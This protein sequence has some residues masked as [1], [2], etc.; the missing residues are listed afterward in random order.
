IP[1]RDW[2]QGMTQGARIAPA[3]ELSAFLEA[4]P[5]IQA[6]Q[7]MITDPSGV[8]R[9]KSVRREELQR[10]FESG[11][12]V[13]GSILGLDITGKDVDDTGLVWDT[14]DADMTARPIAGTLTRAPWLAVPTG[15]LMLTMFD[16]AG[17]PAAAD[18]RHALVRVVERFA[19]A[20]LTPVVA[21][22][23]EF[24]LLKEEPGGRLVPAGAGRVSERQKI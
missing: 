24:Y 5:D 16:A 8:P 3:S 7:I 2:E 12:Q 22:E 1:G 10:I 17:V 9:G 6:V 20:G 11:R 4:H 19:R 13:A 15:Q 23:I 14:G 18:P 21:C